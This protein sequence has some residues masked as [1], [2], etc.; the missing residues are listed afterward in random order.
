MTCGYSLLL[1]G[2]L[3][4]L[5]M[6]SFDAQKLLILIKSY[7]P[8]FHNLIMPLVSYPKNH[9]QIQCHEGF[10]LCFLLR[11]FIVLA[12]MFKSLIYFELNF[13]FGV[14][15]MIQLHSFVCEYH[16]YPAPF[17]EKTALS[18][19]DDLSMLVKNHLTIYRRV[20]FWSL[21]SIL[22]VCVSIFMPLW[23]DQFC[24]HLIFLI[25]LS[26]LWFPL[27]FWAYLRKLL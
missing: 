8:C 24:L 18:P 15:E 17:V 3:V 27:A 25:Y 22:L 10:L 12:L 11:V 23:L 20:Y 16:I 21:C 1:C 13:I 4:T 26:S 14:K 2:C 19:L 6:V 7:L 9:C 5:L